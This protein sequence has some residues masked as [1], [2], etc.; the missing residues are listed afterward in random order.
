MPF[1]RRCLNTSMGSVRGSD[2]LSLRTPRRLRIPLRPRN[3]PAILTDRWTIWTPTGSFTL[4][5]TS[6]VAA[7]RTANSSAKQFASENSRM[8][9][10]PG[11]PAHVGRLAA[12]EPGRPYVCFT[13]K[14]SSTDRSWRGRGSCSSRASRLSVASRLRRHGRTFVGADQPAGWRR[15]PILSSFIATKTL[16]GFGESSGGVAGIGGERQTDIA[17]EYDTLIGK[18][19]VQHN[20]KPEQMCL[21]AGPERFWEAALAFL[22]PGRKLVQA[23]PTF[24]SLGNLR[25]RRRRSG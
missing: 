17:Q 18:L 6:P 20:V 8:S 16:M 1:I 10:T 22:K 23:A 12:M 2:D 15:L 7:W 24:P 13:Q 3:S 5:I 14:S 9:A 25:K 21:A 4:T 11:S 19:A